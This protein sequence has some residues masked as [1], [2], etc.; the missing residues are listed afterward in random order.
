MH[1]KFKIRA[2]KDVGPMQCPTK[3]VKLVLFRLLSTH[4]IKRLKYQMTD[5]TDFYYCRIFYTI[6]I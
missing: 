2:I 6:K 1:L 4:K 5:I 3:K